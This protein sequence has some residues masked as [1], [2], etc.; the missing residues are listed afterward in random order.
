MTKL[1][2][3]FFLNKVVVSLNDGKKCGKVENFLIKNFKTCFLQTQNKNKK[4]LLPLKSVFSV[5]RHYVTIKNQSCFFVATQSCTLNILRKN[6]L[7]TCGKSFGK[8]LNFWISQNFEIDKISTNNFSFSPKQILSIGDVV[9]L[10][11]A[12]LKQTHFAKKHLKIF[13]K[14]MIFDDRVQILPKK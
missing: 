8:I 7:N 2:H 1:N 6:V 14:S 3:N 9:V 5:G 11:N 10:K 4:F 13:Q 12:N